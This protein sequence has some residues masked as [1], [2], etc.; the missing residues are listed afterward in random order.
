MLYYSIMKKKILFIGAHYDDVE[1]GCGGSIKK[2]NKFGHKTKILVISNSEIRDIKNNKILRSKI[3]AKKEFLKSIKILGVSKFD[4]L[5]FDTNKI[6][7]NDKLISK[8]RQQINDFKPNIVFTHWNKDVHQDHKAISEATLSASRHVESLLMYESNN[9]LGDE[10]F[11]GNLFIDTSE[12]FKYK[13]DAIKCYETELKRVKNKWIS[14]I[15]SKDSVSGSFI[16]SQYAEKFKV[17][18]LNYKIEK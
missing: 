6:E 2:F 18:K 7:F 5:N 11:N 16:N 10:I 12:Y 3:S 15:K 1:L 17:I 14:Q 13:L 9:Y 8:I 4:N